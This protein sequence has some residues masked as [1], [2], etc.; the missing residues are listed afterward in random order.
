[1]LR[2]ALLAS[3]ERPTRHAEIPIVLAARACPTTRGFLPWRLS[4]AG[5]GACLTVATGRHPKPLHSLWTNSYI[6]RCL[7]GIELLHFCNSATCHNRRHP[8][9]VMFVG[10]ASHKPE[11]APPAAPKTRQRPKWLRVVLGGF[12]S[13]RGRVEPA[14][15]PRLLHKSYCGL[16]SGVT[17][18]QIQQPNKARKPARHELSQPM[19]SG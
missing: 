14:L 6:A 11:N 5:P 1:M 4:D 2:S 12:Q 9:G 7:T 3:I 16:G 10:F 18:T 19:P 13:A 17:A 8:G 15:A